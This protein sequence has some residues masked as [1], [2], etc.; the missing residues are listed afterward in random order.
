MP[1]TLVPETIKTLS[2][3]RKIAILARAK[4]DFIAAQSETRVILDRLL[5][6]PLAE[7]TREYGPL[8]ADFRPEDLL[9]GDD[10]IEAAIKRVGPDLINALKVARDNVEKF[11]MAQLE[12]SLWLTEIKPGLLAGRT[13]RP[14]DRV[15]VY[16]PGGRA[17]YPSTAL[18]NVIPAKV[19]GVT[20][21]VAATPPGEGLKARPE[22]LAA[23]KVAGAHKIYKLGGAWAVGSLAYGLLGAPK[24]DK[25]VGPGSSWVA[26]AKLAVYGE[27]DIDSPAGPSE[28]FIV[29][30]DG[31]DPDALA[32]DFMAQLEHDPEAAAVLAT[33]SEKLARKV[34]AIVRK[35]APKLD[36]AEIV[37]KSLKNAAI[38]IAADLDEA[39]DFAN[40]YAPEHLQLVVEDPFAL[41]ERVR[42]AGS[43]FLGPNSPIAAG[44]Y[45]SGPNHVLPTGGTARSFSGLSV[46]DF[47][48]KMTFQSLSH[49]ALVDLAPTVETLAR[50]EGLFAHARSVEIRLKKKT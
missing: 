37:Q 6:D 28:G 20:E 16:V 23:L 33:P 42:R 8:K 18:M 36:R 12:R 3:A 30:E 48:R 17:A 39:L 49:K 46:D 50:A 26:A 43:V 5:K 35:E 38:L 31:A 10:E 1:A 25:I 29:A 34:A 13:I 19:A 15:G 24:V 32:W 7:I 44:D 14:L 9:V 2:S 22:I 40:E 11:H 47:L 41:L 27:V 21:I 45:A 4:A